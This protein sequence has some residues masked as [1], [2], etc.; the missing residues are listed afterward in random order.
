MSKVAKYAVQLLLYAF[1]GVTVAYFSAAPAFQ[2]AS[3][4]HAIIKLAFSHA[5]QRVAPCV[6]LSPAEVAALAPNMRR[7]ESCERKRLPLEI[8][9]DVDGVPS[10]SQQVPPSGLWGDGHASVYEKYSLAPGEYRLT[11]RLRDSARDSG[12]DYTHSESVS[13]TAGQYLTITFR[14]ENGGFEIR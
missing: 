12:W 3:S 14:S 1:F 5:T 6:K 2:Y 10:L 7:T 9:L 4:E 11:L 8:E 13:L